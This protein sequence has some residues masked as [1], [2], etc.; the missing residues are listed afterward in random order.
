MTD[1]TIGEGPAGRK[2]ASNLNNFLVFQAFV[3]KVP[4]RQTAIRGK[5]ASCVLKAN[6]IQ[7]PRPAMSA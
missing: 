3:S 1:A 6:M 5:L 7:L 2:R 4:F